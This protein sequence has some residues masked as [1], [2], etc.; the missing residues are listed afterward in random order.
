MTLDLRD[1]MKMIAE[2]KPEGALG[3]SLEFDCKIEVD[4][5]KPLVKVLNYMCNFL[6]QNAPDG[7]IVQVSLNA[8]ADK[9]LLNFAAKTKMAEKPELNSQIPDVLKD[10]DAE[11]QYDFTPNEF[12]MILVSFD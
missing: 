5:P 1:V 4:D 7:E 11:V 3:L 8:S 10:Y 2:S 9:L 12:A 6:A